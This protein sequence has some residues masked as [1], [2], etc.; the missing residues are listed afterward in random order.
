MLLLE[1]YLKCT[2]KKKGPKMYHS[3]L[4]D[5]NKLNIKQSVM[6]ISIFHKVRIKQNSIVYTLHI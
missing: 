2:W 4:V 3:W 5:C 6:T 1:R